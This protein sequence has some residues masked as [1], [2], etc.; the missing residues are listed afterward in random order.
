MFFNLRRAAL[1]HAASGD[2]PKD[3]LVPLGLL[4]VVL[5]SMGLTSP[6]TEQVFPTLTPAQIRRIAAQGHVRSTQPGEVLVQQGDSEGAFFVVVSG[7]LEVLRPA[8]SA[9]TLVT[10]HG[11]GHFTGEVSTLFGPG[12][13]FSP[14]RIPSLNASRRP[15]FIFHS[16]AR[17]N[18]N[19][20][21]WRID[22]TFQILHSCPVPGCE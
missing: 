15:L 8:G 19:C 5:I 9:E 7:E 3:I 16:P 13:K 14:L 2:P 20:T 12:A 21:K 6:R 1:S 10:V 18:N 17:T 22:S 4:V 11:P